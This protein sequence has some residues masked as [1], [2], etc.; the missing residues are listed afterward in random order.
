MIP[1]VQ[2]TPLLQMV[3]LLHVIPLLVQV[4]PLLKVVPLLLQMVSLLLQMIPLRV[5]VVSLLLQLLSLVHVIPLLVQ[6]MLSTC[7]HAQAAARALCQRQLPLRRLRPRQQSVPP[8]ARARAL[9]RV[10]PVNLRSLARTILT[11]AHLLRQQ[12]Q[13]VNLSQRNLK[14]QQ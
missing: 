5:Q 2:T 1:L 10:T 6:V 3:S 14:V 12:R 11:T 7:R 13:S 9:V 8:V 4:I